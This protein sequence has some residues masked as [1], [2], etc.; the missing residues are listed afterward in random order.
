M[1]EALAWQG[2]HNLWA[3]KE[4]RASQVLAAPPTRQHTL[5]PAVTALRSCNRHTLAATMPSQ[6]QHQGHAAASSLHDGAFGRQKTRALSLGSGLRVLLVQHAMVLLGVGP[7][8]GRMRVEWR[9]VVGL[10]QQGL[11]VQECRQRHWKLQLPLSSAL[12]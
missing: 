11:R 7:Q 12:A 6:V 9:V 3:C 1:Q 4:R 10:A 5:S 2:D 8:L